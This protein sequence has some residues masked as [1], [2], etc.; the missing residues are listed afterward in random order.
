MLK[1]AEVDF[2]LE[3]AKRLKQSNDYIMQKRLGLPED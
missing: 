2:E 3:E 1:E